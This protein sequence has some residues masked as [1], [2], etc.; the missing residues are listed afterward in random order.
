MLTPKVQKERNIN[1]FKVNEG[2]LYI[3]RPEHTH[4][5]H[6]TY[7]L[8]HASGKSQYNNEISTIFG[9]NGNK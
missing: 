5:E 8:K 1:I 2:D 7:T 3:S 9:H 4:P 6:P